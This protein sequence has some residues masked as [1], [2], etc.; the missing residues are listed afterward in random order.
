MSMDGRGDFVLPT[1]PSS[2]G[3]LQNRAENNILNKSLITRQHYNEKFL[4]SEL[5]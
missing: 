4:Q 3:R 1:S 5:K 2:D